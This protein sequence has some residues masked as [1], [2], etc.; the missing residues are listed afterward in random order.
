MAET[1]SP[2]DNLSLSRHERRSQRLINEFIRQ[3]RTNRSDVIVARKDASVITE[4]ACCA[5]IAQSAR[6][7][8]R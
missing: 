6:L 1:A 4:R 2:F 7:L 5:I 8:G 3:I